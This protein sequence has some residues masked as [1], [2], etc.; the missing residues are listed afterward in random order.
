MLDLDRDYQIIKATPLRGPWSAQHQKNYGIYQE[1]PELRMLYSPLEGG[2]HSRADRIVAVHDPI[3]VDNARSIGAD[4][5]EARRA[6]D[7]EATNE[8]RSRRDRSAHPDVV[9][10]DAVNMSPHRMRRCGSRCAA[11]RNSCRSTARSIGGWGSR[12]AAASEAGGYKFYW[13]YWFEVDGAGAMLSLS[14]PFKIDADV[15]IEFAAGLALDR[16]NSE[17]VVSYGV[18]DDHAMIGVTELQRGACSSFVLS[19]RTPNL[20]LSRR[21]AKMIFHDPRTNRS[22]HGRSD[23]AMEGDA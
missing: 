21:R 23:A 6:S 7:L 3:H 4:A 18:E 8:V 10:Y 9:R 14:D 2:V 20:P 22:G 11:A 5:A 12:T 19:A 17:L 15:G 13:H 16:A 1:S